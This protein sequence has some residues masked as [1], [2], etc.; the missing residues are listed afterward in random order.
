MR[1]ASESETRE[2]VSVLPGVTGED[3]TVTAGKTVESEVFVERGVPSSPAPKV[4]V[5][6][7]KF[8]PTAV[9]RRFSLSTLAPLGVGNPAPEDQWTSSTIVEEGLRITIESTV[10]PKE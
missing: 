4:A 1:P 7:E 6:A 3:G 8:E 9:P 5:A 2:R 10:S